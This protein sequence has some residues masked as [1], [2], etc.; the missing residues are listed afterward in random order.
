[1]KIPLTFFPQEKKIQ[2]NICT[3][4]QE[5]HSSQNN[6]EKNHK[7]G[8]VPVLD[9]KIH[10]KATVGNTIWNCHKT[11]LTVTGAEQRDQGESI[12]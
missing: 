10:Y 8:F 7:A 1:M 6:L 2:S 9:F 12:R 3:E 5:T 11:R 4:S